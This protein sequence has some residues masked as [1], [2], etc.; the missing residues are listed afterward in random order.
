MRVSS[1][2]K[3]V[4]YRPEFK[5]IANMGIL[6]HKANDYDVETG[7]A[8]KQV[9]GDN[10]SSEFIGDEGAVHAETF[11]IGDSFYAK[12]QRFATRFGVEARGI[13]RVPSSERTDAGMSKIGTLVCNTVLSRQR[14]QLISSGSGYL[15][16]WS[17]LLSPLVPWPIPSFTLAL[18]I[19]SSRFSSLTFLEYCPFASSPHSAQ[20]SACVRWFFPGS[21]LAGME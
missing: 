3:I 9:H 6:P 12:A 2:L 19:P 1:L 10:S 8:E 11:I 15:P 5:Y 13:E 7:V 16:I 4:S 20:D 21:S 18:S 14:T 17:Y